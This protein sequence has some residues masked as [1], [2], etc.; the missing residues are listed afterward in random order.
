MQP[1]LISSILIICLILL[2]F[3]FINEFEDAKGH[4]LQAALQ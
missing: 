1:L 4:G 3:F 2:L